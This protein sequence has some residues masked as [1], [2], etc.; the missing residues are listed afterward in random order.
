MTSLMPKSVQDDNWSTENGPSEIGHFPGGGARAVVD[1]GLS[2]KDVAA[3]TRGWQE[4][5]LAAHHR[6]LK[7]NAFDW[8]LLNCPHYPTAFNHGCDGAA[9][10]APDRDTTHPQPGCSA[11]MRKYCGAHSPFNSMALMFG[12]TRASQYDPLFANN[13][14]LPFF[15]EDL[16]TFLCVR[17]RYAWL[18]YGFQG[19]AGDT[20]NP[21]PGETWRESGYVFP[22]ELS[23]DY[24]EP[25]GFCH[26]TSSGSEVFQREY[27]RATITMDCGNFKGSIE[28]K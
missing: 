9:V 13:L 22:P 4:T 7:S 11:F 25:Q 15:K 20:G 1:M 3:I 17:G 28:M 14:S 6:V 18:G 26:E 16:A 5:M 12:F 10:S 8:Q 19:C 2:P 21:F 27:T 23:V 24:G